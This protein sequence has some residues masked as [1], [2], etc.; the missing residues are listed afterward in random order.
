MLIRKGDLFEES[1]IERSCSF[2]PPASPGIFG[3]SDQEV[4]LSVGMNGSRNRLYEAENFSN[5]NDD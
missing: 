1:L 2:L 5:R 4:C 3:P